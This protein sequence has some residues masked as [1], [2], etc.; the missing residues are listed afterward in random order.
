MEELHA[1]GDEGLKAD[2]IIVDLDKDKKI[3][4]LMNLAIVEA[5]SNPAKTI[6]IIGN[7]VRNKKMCNIIATFLFNLNIKSA[8]LLVRK[9]TFKRMFTST[10]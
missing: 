3:E 8:I 7:L 5:Q 6:T 4:R 10:D 2:V 1:L 9:Q